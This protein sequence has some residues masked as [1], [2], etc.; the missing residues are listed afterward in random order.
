VSIAFTPSFAF[1][2]L[3]GRHYDRLRHDERV[4]AFLSGARP[5]AVGAITGA[6]IPLGLAPDHSLV[7]Q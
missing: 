2:L 1:I 4:Q 6:A 7:L 3:R 5:A